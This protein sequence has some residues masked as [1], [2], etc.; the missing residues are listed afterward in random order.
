MYKLIEIF[1]F[2]LQLI[3]ALYLL[4]P[5]ISL[6][7]FFLRKNKSDLTSK[8]I[9]IHDHAFIVTAYKNSLNLDN[10]IDSILKQNYSTYIVYIVADDCPDYQIK[11]SESRIVLLKP[12]EIFAN[13]IK[14]HFFAIENFKRQ[15]EFL[16]II[17]SDNLVERD[18]LI[19]ID[20][21]INKGFNAI[22]G[23]RK[24]KN[25]NTPLACI[26]AMNEIYYVYYDRKILFSIG[27]S[28]MLSGS[29]MTFSVDLYRE[30]MENIKNSGAGFDKILQKEIIGRGYRIAFAERAIV[31]DEKTSNKDQIIK[32]RAR[33]N[34]TWFKYYKSGIKLMIQGLLQLNLNKILY[35]FV[36]SR[37]PLFLLLLLVFI[38]FCINLWVNIKV[39]FLWLFFG[40]LFLLGFLLSLLNSETDTRIYKS[41]VY[42]PKFI[43][44]QIL[45]LFKARKANTFSVA[46]EH[47]VIK[48]IDSIQ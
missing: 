29:G 23:L 5:F 27:S 22:Q 4:F 20:R 44:L 31:F 10:V 6:I 48:N 19:E 45:S 39:A 28:S 37:P 38:F 25:L 21:F 24:A 16:T 42:I 13:Q 47:N 36:L 41:I 12:S 17:D 26:D 7:F 1:W 18:F 15:H 34:N 35:G 43:W 3:A 11:V 2:I 8:A 46:T 32:Q 30:C 40:G 33:W 14:S 9:K